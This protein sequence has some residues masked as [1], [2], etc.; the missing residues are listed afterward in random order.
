MTAIYKF[1]YHAIELSPPKERQY[2]A[3]FLPHILKSTRKL[4]YVLDEILKVDNIQGI[5][6]KS[7]FPFGREVVSK[8]AGTEGFHSPRRHN[9]HRF[10]NHFFA[11]RFHAMSKD[12]SS[13]SIPAPEDNVKPLDYKEQFSVCSVLWLL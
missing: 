8:P 2:L 5:R 1:L 13:T 4:G 6:Q 9:I 3:L 12:N 11:P 10:G 7:F